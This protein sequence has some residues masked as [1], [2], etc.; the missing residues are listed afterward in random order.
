MATALAEKEGC[1]C[2]FIETLVVLEKFK[3]ETVWHGLVSVFGLQRPEEELCYAWFDSD[4]KTLVTVL[5]RPPVESPAT[6]VRTYI[7]SRARDA[8]VRQP[9][10]MS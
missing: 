8:I 5:N 6:A 2:R 1:P 7:A 4:G 3:E 9:N 10:R